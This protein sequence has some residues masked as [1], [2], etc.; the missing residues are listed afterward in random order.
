ML[1]NSRM[2]GIYS[3]IQS[4]TLGAVVGNFSDMLQYA[5]LARKRCI[6]IYQTTNNQSGRIRS[7]ILKYV[8]RILVENLGVKLVCL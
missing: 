3:Q 4:I 6:W 1:V 7:P 8:P 2:V 5:N